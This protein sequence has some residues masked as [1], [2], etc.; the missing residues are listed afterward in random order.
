MKDNTERIKMLIRR[1][2]VNSI[3]LSMFDG[4]DDEDQR[5]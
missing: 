5:L 4:L 3:D 2:Q 1:G